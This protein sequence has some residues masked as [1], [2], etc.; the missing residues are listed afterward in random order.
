MFS[1]AVGIPLQEKLTS[2][3]KA[4]RPDGSTVSATRGEIEEV[5]HSPIHFCTI[6]RCMPLHEEDG[7]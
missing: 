3:V 2:L 6:A 5:N 1:S 7:Q 4:F